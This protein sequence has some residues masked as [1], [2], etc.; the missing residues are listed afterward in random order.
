MPLLLGVPLLSTIQ[1]ST[2]KVTK[3]KYSW[4]RAASAEWQSSTV[5][6]VEKVSARFLA[7]I[8]PNEL[9]CEHPCT[10]RRDKCT[11]GQG[12]CTFREDQCSKG[13]GQCTLVARISAPEERTSGKVWSGELVNTLASR[14]GHLYLP[15]RQADNDNDT[16][17]RVHRQWHLTETVPVR[18]QGKELSTVLPGAHLLV[19]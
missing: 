16:F 3:L 17:I 12:Q 19:T 6:F 14:E 9:S 11:N 7:W 1:L 5:I 4:Y 10:F 18:V 13:R 2:L 8:S 15:T